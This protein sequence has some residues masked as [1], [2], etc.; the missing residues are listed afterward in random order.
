MYT[1]R[2]RKRLKRGRLYALAAVSA[3][4]CGGATIIVLLRALF[5]GEPVA[6]VPKYNRLA[7]Q[8]V[9]SINSHKPLNL[10][11]THRNYALVSETASGEKQHPVLCLI[12]KTMTRPPFRLC[13]VDP[14]GP[15][16][17]DFG[18]P[19][20][21]SRLVHLSGSARLMSHWPLRTLLSENTD[22]RNPVVIDVGA[23]IGYFSLEAATNGASV[24]AIEHEEALARLI[25]TSAL[26]N[27]KPQNKEL[28]PH[29]DFSKRLRVIHRSA[30]DGTGNSFT[31]D[32]LDIV[33]PEVHILRIA[34]SN[35]IDSIIRGAHELLS[36]HRV[37]FMFLDFSP[38]KLQKQGVDPQDLLRRLKQVYHFN[39]FSDRTA[40][41]GAL[42]EKEFGSLLKGIQKATR[43]IF[44]ARA[45]L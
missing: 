5:A 33:A 3:V 37:R 8:T 25:E 20:Y 12:S 26:L 39:I 23:S 24:I 15:G 7:E 36:G 32:E 35:D 4:C 16:N 19:Q 34:A 9:H 42:L 1:K 21:W 13:T 30:G 38:S 31:L 11:R 27:S 17:L 41:G 18:S 28:K 40:E 22:K 10:R 14:E 45:S 44:L 43:T 2:R 6:V 29:A